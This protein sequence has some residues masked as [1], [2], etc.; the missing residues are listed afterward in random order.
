MKRVLSFVIFTC[1]CLCSCGYGI[2][3]ENQAFVIAVGLDKGESFPLK[4]S[5]VFANPGGTGSAQGES[6]STPKPDIVTVEAPTVFSAVRK[7]DSIKSK[8]INLSHTKVVV[9]S[10]DKAKDGIKEYLSGFASSRDFRPNTYV[11]VSECEAEK[12]LRSVKPVHET[13]IEKYFDNIMQ[14]VTQDK[15]SEAYLYYL[16]YNMTEDYSG[17]LVPLVGVNKNDLS[18]ENISASKNTHDDFTYE[19]RAGEILRKGK[20]PAEVLGSAVFKNDKMIT[21]LGSFHTDLARIIC[22]EFYPR[23]YSISYPG[24]A[25]FVTF[26]M[27]QNQRTE[28]N[29]LIVDNNAKINIKI[30]VSIE[31]IDAGKIESQTNDSE[32]FSGH[33]ERT[34]NKEASSLIRNFQLTHG[35]DLLGL[36]D[37]LKKH[38]PDMKSWK[39]FNWEEKYPRADI[40]V[41]FDVIYA[42]FEE[43]N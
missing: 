18:A 42:D 39:N 1:L 6:P 36:G 33:L 26:R 11:C 37:S 14:K 7:L 35:C 19:V 32:K 31:Y 28:V 17:S 4:V 10:Q 24:K 43:A 41:N 13:F 29:S 30:P 38:F 23:I 40:S 12:Y 9:F 20:N 22:N 2:D 3:V 21:K 5:F 27:S 8:A 25:D 34:L 16:Y 15:V